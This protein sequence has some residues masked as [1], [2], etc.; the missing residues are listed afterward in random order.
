MLEWPHLNLPDELRFD[1]R[2]AE[3]SRE[4]LVQMGRDDV[5]FIMDGR[6]QRCERQTMV[7]EIT[8]AEHVD[9]QRHDQRPQ[10]VIET[11]SRVRKRVPEGGNHNT[12]DAGIR[13]SQVFLV[14]SRH[15]SL[16]EK[17]IYI[18]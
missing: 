6:V 7:A 9:Q 2:V 1:L 8:V 5:H 12:T 3:Y 17:N 14:K 15:V 16:R 4:Q 13:A 11:I 18:E 10:D